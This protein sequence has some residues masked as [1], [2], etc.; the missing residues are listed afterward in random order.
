MFDYP[1][2][3]PRGTAYDELGIAPHATSEEV[4]EAKRERGGAIDEELREVRQRLAKAQEEAPATGKA[5]EEAKLLKQRAEELENK[6][7]A[8]NSLPLQNTEQREAYDLANPPLD[9]LRLV[10]CTVGLFPGAP[11]PRRQLAALRRELAAHFEALG[12][13]AFHPSDLTRDDFSDD[14]TPNP[15]LDDAG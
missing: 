6:K 5:H 12:E 1:L 7:L 4:S 11:A 10:D 9:L 2:P 13:E 14:F 8:L 3:L 15:V